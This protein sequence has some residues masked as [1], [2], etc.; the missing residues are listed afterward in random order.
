MPPPGPPAPRVEPDRGLIWAADGRPRLTWIG[1]SSFLGTL[2]DEHF[3]VDPVFSS[4]IGGFYRRWGEPGLYPEDV[5]PV[6]AVLI[7]HNHYDHLD[8]PSL[9]AL[10]PRPR[11]IGPKGIGRYL[12]RRFAVTELGWWDSVDLDRLRVTFVPAS[13]WSR[14]TFLDINRS[15][16]GGFVVEGTEDSIYHAGDTAD[17]DGFGEIGQAFPELS[18]AILPIGGYEPAWFMAQ[19]HMNPEQAGEAARVLGARRVLP[20]HWGTFRLTDEPLIEPPARLATWWHDNGLSPEQ[21]LVIP[22]VG[23]TVLLDRPHAKSTTE[24]APAARRT[25]VPA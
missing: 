7:S 23:E 1:H 25:A 6:A 16:W 5:P 24:R 14:R 9:S 10:S 11:I 3:L 4:R 21:E 19:S 13:H 8:L 20:M 15:W 18:A 2:D 22:D 12:G 17:F